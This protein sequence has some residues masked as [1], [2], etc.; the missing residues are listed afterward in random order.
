V[1]LDLYYDGPGGNVMVLPMDQSFDAY[2]AERLRTADTLLL[3]RNSYELFRGFWP[4]VADD[5]NATPTEREISDLD[6]AIEKVVVS[7]SIGVDQ[8][9]PWSDTTGI[10]RRANAREQVAKLK[11]G[12]GRDILVFGS[13]TLWNDLLR[14]GLLDELHLRVRPSSWAEGR[15]PSIPSRL[16]RSAC[17]TRE[18]GRAR[19][20]CSSGTPPPRRHDLPLSL[21]RGRL[22]SVTRRAVS[23]RLNP[24]PI[25]VPR[26]PS[27]VSSQLWP[28]PTSTLRSAGMNASSDA[29]PMLSQ[30][31][32]WR[33][34]TSPGAA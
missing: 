3:G 34:G 22:G 26:C 29:P 25:G 4:K 8:T 16:P 12:P 24:D 15:R 23:P 13:R 28:S 20:T 7:D 21:G 11:Q 5:P 18:R 14:A 30:W 32:A 1:S 2:K 6:D 17:S 10:V 19:T 27:T 9:E 33:S 31:T